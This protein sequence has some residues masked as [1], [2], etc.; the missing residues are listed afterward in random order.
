[1]EPNFPPFDQ[2]RSLATAQ[3]S[4]PALALAR[5]WTPVAG[6][7]PHDPTAAHR[8]RAAP[9]ASS[10][11]ALAPAL[12]YRNRVTGRRP[13]RPGDSGSRHSG[14]PPSFG[15]AVAELSEDRR[16]VVT[17]A[18]LVTVWN[19][20]GDCARLLLRSNHRGSSGVKWW[21]FHSF[22]RKIV[23]R[24]PDMEHSLIQN[25]VEHPIYGEHEEDNSMKVEVAFDG[26]HSPFRYRH[27]KRSK[28]WE[29]YKPIFLS[30]KVQYAE[31]LYC[32]N[33]LSCK[34]SNGTSHLWRHQKICPG[35]EEAAQRREKNSYFPRVVVNENNPVSPNDPVN[36]II[37]ETVGDI[38]SVTP[39]RFTS[40]SRVQDE[41]SPALTNGKVQIAEYS[42]K[43]LRTSSSGDSTPKPI[44]VVP[45]QH[46]LPTPDCTSLKKQKTSFMTTS[47]GQETSYTELARMI[48]LHGYP[49][50]IV[51]HEEMRELVKNLNPVGNAVSRNAME[52]HCFTLFQKEKANLKESE[53]GSYNVIWDAIRD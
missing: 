23:S 6:K 18:C 4:S 7:P 31:C 36:E 29:E 41:L 47:A 2:P 38:N 33:R 15:L 17:S 44:R 28:V 5:I 19:G 50:S 9:A 30:G 39:S 12:A 3:G 45:A 51:E 26:V 49:L 21:V 42:S 10:S 16:M 22:S 35:K 24:I 1:M 25:T 48:I 14:L 11:S 43:L 8:Y 32:H 52:E 13:A 40:K 37:T 53:S 20:D 34:D 27:K 46:P